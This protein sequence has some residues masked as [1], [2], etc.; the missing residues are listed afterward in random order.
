MTHPES[1]RLFAQID[2]AKSVKEDLDKLSP[3][4]PTHPADSDGNPCMCPDCRYRPR[5]GRTY[6]PR[7]TEETPSND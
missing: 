1:L 6:A 4:P 5:E 3:P 7:T 2:F